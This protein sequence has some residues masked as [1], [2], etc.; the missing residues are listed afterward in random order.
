[1]QTSQVETYDIRQRQYTRRG[2]MIIWVGAGL[3]ALIGL[4]NTG[5]FNTAPGLLKALDATAIVIG[6]AFLGSARV[7][8]E[9]QATLI[10]RGLE[11]QKFAGTD[12]IPKEMKWPKD[13]EDCWTSGMFCVL[14]AGVIMLVCFWW[15]VSWRTS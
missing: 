8:F 6:G 4:A 10:K 2:D 11:D 15:Q 9:W 5:T 12:P 1:M 3:A 7:K 14:A 13:A